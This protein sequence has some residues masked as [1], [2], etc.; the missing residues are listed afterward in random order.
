MGELAERMEELDKNKSIYVICR[1]GTRSDLAAKQLAEAGF[2]KIYN[3]LPGMTGY[4]GEL[5][6]EVK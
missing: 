5:E 4:E 2:S 3:V 6:K 1:T